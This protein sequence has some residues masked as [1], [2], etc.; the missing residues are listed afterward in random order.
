[1]KVRSVL[2]AISQKFKISIIHNILALEELYE[3]R[4]MK[5]N[6][7]VKVCVKWRFDQFFMHCLENIKLYSFPAY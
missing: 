3:Y 6:M 2:H 5:K 1:V 4:F 7:M